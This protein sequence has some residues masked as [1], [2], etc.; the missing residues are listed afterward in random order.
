LD[1]RQPLVARCGCSLGRRGA[2]MRCDGIEQTEPVG[3]RRF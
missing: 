1:L 3:V 2:V